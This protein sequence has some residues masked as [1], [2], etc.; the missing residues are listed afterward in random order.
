MAVRFKKL[1]S[2]NIKETLL[3]HFQNLFQLCMEYGLLGELQFKNE[4]SHDLQIFH[5]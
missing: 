4:E 3:L 2:A 1:S 5:I